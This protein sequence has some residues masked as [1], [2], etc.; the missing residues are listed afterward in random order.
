LSISI[1]ASQLKCLLQRAKRRGG[2]LSA[3]IAE[4]IRLVRQREARERLLQRFRAEDG[5]VPPKEARN[6][7]AEWLS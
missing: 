3:V 1:D 4:A 5:R 7:I 2:H 6:I